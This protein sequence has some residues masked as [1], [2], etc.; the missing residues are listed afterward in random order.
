MIFR[1]LNDDKTLYP[2]REIMA[3]IKRSSRVALSR[4]P[5]MNPA[6]TQDAAFGRNLGRSGP[7]SGG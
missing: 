5:P 4:H 7:I 3:D 1:K 6:R 2:A